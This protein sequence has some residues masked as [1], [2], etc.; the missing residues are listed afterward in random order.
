MKIGI[1]KEIKNNEFRVGITPEGA[2]K[3]VS[4][5]HTVLVENNAGLGSGFTNNDY[6]NI[7]AEIISFPEEIYASADMIIKVK[8][9]LQSEY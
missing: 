5:K 1:P 2:K 7:G 9:P 4:Q 8:E 6:L 3:I